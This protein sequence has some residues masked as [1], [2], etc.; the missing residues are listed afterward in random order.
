MHV[1]QGAALLG[2]LAVSCTGLE[3]ESPE[4]GEDG[5]AVKAP[6]AISSVATADGYTEIRQGDSAELVIR[7]RGLG[8]VDTVTLDSF[9]GAI[10]AEVL[11]AGDKEVRARIE[12]PHGQFG[13]QTITLSGPNGSAS[14]VDAL[15]F[16]EYIVAADAGTGGKGT[17]QSPLA[18][19]D[20][21]VQ[22]AVGGD[23]VVLLAGEHRCDAV[24][25]LRAGGQ[26]IYGQGPGVTVVRGDTSSFGGFLLGAGTSLQDFT[27]IAPD[28]AAGAAIISRGTDN[29]LNTSGLEVVGSGV[30]LEAAASSFVSGQFRSTRIAGAPVAIA[31]SGLAVVD[32]REG[33]IADCT[34]GVDIAS[35]TLVV[36]DST[37]ERCDVG[38]HVRRTPAGGMPVRSV[39]AENRLLDLRVGAHVE[40]GDF[41]LAGGIVA[42]DETTPK[43]SERGV[44][45]ENGQVSVTFTTITGQSIAGVEAAVRG[46]SAGGELRA[47]I[48]EIIIEGGQYGVL[49]R[50]PSEPG[51]FIV[52]GSAV[53]RDQTV[54]SVSVGIAG[55]FTVGLSSDCCGTELSIASGFALEDVRTEPGV[56]IA[57]DP[58]IRLNGATFS[59]LV[60][61][62]AEL[63]PYYRIATEAG[64]IQF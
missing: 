45:V 51:S 63:P 57:A 33:S 16:T 27:I 11:R 60:T 32:F 25:D 40:D 1:R 24:L 39:I 36:I 47:M 5:I 52:Q 34:T 12:V 17:H 37:V 3:A 44:L 59:G 13:L 56:T 61:G 4:R 29:F 28:P 10:E 41:T 35:G 26:Y 8:R 19:C 9:N 30:V 62:P 49:L 2:V 48:G 50:G 6:M 64:A 15:R 58:P 23:I 31:A 55:P 7:G 21:A 20:P 42:D 22:T 54:A 43:E 38:L 46:G 18:L 53:L 14:A